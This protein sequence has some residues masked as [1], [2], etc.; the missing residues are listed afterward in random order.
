[1]MTRQMVNSERNAIA[2]VIRIEIKTNCWICEQEIKEG[3]LF[4]GTL[5]KDAHNF[6]HAKCWKEPE[7]HGW[8]A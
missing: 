1:M 4:V 5:K 7:K 2:P 6:Y 3:D 8:M